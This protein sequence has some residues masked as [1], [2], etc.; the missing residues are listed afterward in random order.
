MTACSWVSW[1]TESA[2]HYVTAETR[3][4]LVLS[5]VVCTEHLDRARAGGYRRRGSADDA[6]AQH[7]SADMSRRRV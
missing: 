3:P 1:C 2:E 7:A 5:E 4:G 6:P